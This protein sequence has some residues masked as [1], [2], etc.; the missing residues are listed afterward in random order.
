MESLKQLFLSCGSPD[1]LNNAETKKKPKL[2][3]LVKT[4]S[5]EFAKK[6]NDRDAELEKI[7][8]DNEELEKAKKVNTSN[9]KFQY[10]QNCWPN[11]TGGRRRKKRR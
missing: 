11:S 10:L 4:L 6:Y 2:T 1:S 7:R 9:K 3:L 5:V 8:K